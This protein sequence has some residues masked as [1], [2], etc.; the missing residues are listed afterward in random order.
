[1][2]LNHPTFSIIGTVVYTS[3]LKS[4]LLISHQCLSIQLSLLF[5]IIIIL[6]FS[7]ET[8][9]KLIDFGCAILWDDKGEHAAG[10]PEYMAPEVLYPAM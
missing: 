3:G 2:I 8:P 1:M 6:F 4:L 7:L 5:V 9:L 10:T